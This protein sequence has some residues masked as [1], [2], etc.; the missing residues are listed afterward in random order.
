[1]KGKYTLLSSRENLTLAGR[2]SL[3]L[4]LAANKRINTAYLL[5]RVQPTRRAPALALRKV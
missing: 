5:R 4:L 2:G 1:M 3:K